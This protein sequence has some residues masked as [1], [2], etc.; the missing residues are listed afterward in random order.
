MKTFFVFLLRN[1]L[2][3]AINFIGLAI[4]LA[5]VFLIASYTVKQLQT[6]KFQEHADRVYLLG[7]KRG[8]GNGFYWLQRLLVERYP[9]IECAISLEADKL[10]VYSDDPTASTSE[11]CLLADSAYFDMLTH[12]IIEGDV[13][14]FKIARQYCVVSQSYARRVFGKDSPV[15]ERVT[16]V[17]ETREYNFIIAAVMEDID[18]SF[19]PNADLIVPAED[20]MLA[21]S[22]GNGPNLSTNTVCYTLV[23]IHEGADIHAKCDE[24]EAWFK[25]ILWNYRRGSSQLVRFVPIDELYFAKTFR[26]D[27]RSHFQAGDREFVSVLITV[28]VVLLVFALLNYVNLT[29][30][31]SGFR[32][33]EMA[34][35]RLLGTR[36][37]VIFM[38]LVAE[39]LVLSIGAALLALLLAYALL[40]HACDLLKYQFGLFD[41]FTTMHYLLLTVCVL[42]I[43]LSAGIFPALF[44]SGFNPMDVVKGTF[45]VKSKNVYGKVMIGVQYTLAIVMLLMACTIRLQMRHIIEAPLGYNTE[46]YMTVN[47]SGYKGLDHSALRAELMTCPQVEKVG[48]GTG[49]PYYVDMDNTPVTYQGRTL[50]MMHIYGDSLYFDILGLRVKHDNK[51][52][53]PTP[54]LNE[55]AIEFFGMKDTDVMTPED[56][57]N[58]PFSVGGVYYNFHFRNR[59]ANKRGARIYNFGS[60][61]P[62]MLQ[63]AVIKTVGPH[64]EA[65]QAVIDVFNELYPGELELS[66]DRARYVEESIANGL[67]KERRLLQIVSIF[68]LLSLF[69]ATLGL[70]GMSTYYVR[71]RMR[72]IAIKRTFGTSRLRIVCGLLGHF[73]LIVGIAFVVALPIAFHITEQWLSGYDYRMSQSGWLYLLVGLFV[74]VIAFLT[75]FGLSVKAANA[76][77]VEVLRKE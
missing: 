61:I 52:G 27:K 33:K 43:G 44:I 30:A 29:M 24:M 16:V 58:H 71:Q 62:R 5:F 67:S 49:H 77:P 64:R 9:E 54:F 35:R 39:S 74:I 57:H 2:Y 1:K 25:E 56:E 66:P 53:E 7:N 36:R 55:W 48:F 32:A 4:S 50:S 31:Q 59:L 46:D 45:R 10:K 11:L 47:L 8:H 28:G 40:P 19:L 22:W 42:L 51:L 26:H 72:D 63:T 38:R 75:V 65:Q 13:K 60:E 23:K 18:N 76:N 41:S 70:F 15:G 37:S 3:T 12:R 20:I 34:M 73:L 69:V 6:D 68:T 17:D 21:Q 14:K